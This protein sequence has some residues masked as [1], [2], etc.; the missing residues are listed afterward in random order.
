MMRHSKSIRN[1]AR[2]LFLL[3]LPIVGLLAAC[4]SKATAPVEITVPPTTAAPAYTPEPDLAFRGQ[5]WELRAS[6]EIVEY[7][8]ERP[9]QLRVDYRVTNHL[10]LAITR[11]RF[12]LG[13]LGA[14][15]NMLNTASVTV[16][17][18]EQPLA[19]GETRQFSRTH[20]FTGA[21]ATAALLVTP[22]SAETERELA[23]WADPRPDN[24][25]VDFC[26]DPVLS[27][28]FAALDTALPEALLYQEDQVR[29]TAVTDPALIRQ[30]LEALAQVRIGQMSE[31][32]VDDGGFTYTFF[33]DDGTSWSLRFDYRTLF[34]WHGRNYEVLDASALLALELPES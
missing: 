7:T 16:S 29:E 33:M 8:S 26:N 27:A 14:D 1:A 18:E 21:E 23:P 13:C 3:L 25:L 20:Y 9:G 30:V 32:N 22:L 5:D 15:G 31:R 28:R 6:L 34:F 4:G 11:L 24:L 2:F 19:A 12:Q 10:S 17:L